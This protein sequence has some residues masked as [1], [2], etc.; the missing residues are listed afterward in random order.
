MSE[1][2]KIYE[3]EGTK[4]NTQEI[5]MTVYSALSKRK[6]YLDRLNKIKNLANSFVG[7]TS[8][9]AKDIDGMS[10][11]EFENHIKSVYDK[12]VAIIRNFYELN[13]AITKSNAL[14][15]LVIAGKNYTV[16][17]AIVRYD[18]LNSEIEFLNS[19]AKDVARA[20]ASVSRHN[21]ENLSEKAVTDHVKRMMETV[22]GS[23]TIDQAD[24]TLVAMQEKFREDYI[25]RNT[26]TIIDPYK[27]SETIQ[28]RMD[29]IQEF[30][31]EFNEAI[32]ICNMKTV[33]KVN[34]VTD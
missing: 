34:L 19:I 33:I 30:I 14:T 6:I 16:A 15:E 11:E 3:T 22:V 26:Y 25:D 28:A 7:V 24:S 18:R 31:S 9:S 5:E 23:G 4:T 12:S 32:N 8:K 29:E 17:E 1:I 20:K 27:H 10:K 21:T 2:G 13:A